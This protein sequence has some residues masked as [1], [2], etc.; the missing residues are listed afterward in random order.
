MHKTVGRLDIGYTLTQNR[1]DILHE[2][3]IASED[4]SDYHT[5]AVEHKSSTP[6]NNNLGSTSGIDRPE[7][8]PTRVSPGQANVP[9]PDSI[10]EL[11]DTPMQ[12]IPSCALTAGVVKKDCVDRVLCTPDRLSV[13]VEGISHT[14]SHPPPENFDQMQCTPMSSTEDKGLKLKFT[15]SKGENSQK[16]KR[17]RSAAGLDASNSLSDVSFMELLSGIEAPTPPVTRSK[18]K[19]ISKK[20]KVVDTGSK[21]VLCSECGE[22]VK[23]STKCL[24]C[25][26]CGAPACEKCMD[27]PKQVLESLQ[28]GSLDS[29][30]FTCKDCRDKVRNSGASKLVKKTIVPEGSGKNSCD[31]IFESKFDILAA[32]MGSLVTQMSTMS[33]TL[34]G[35]NKTCGDIKSELAKKADKEEVETLSK[36]VEA[37]KAKVVTLENVRRDMPVVQD[38]AL[39]DRMD[40]VK[41]SITSEYKDKFEEVVGRFDSLELKLRQEERRKSNVIV[42]GRKESDA[43]NSDQR[44]KEDV[45]FIDQL[46]G[47]ARSEYKAVIFRRA[48]YRLG[49]RA[50]GKHRNIKI[51]LGNQQQRDVFLESMKSQKVDNAV[52]FSIDRSKEERETY[53][54]L[55]A[56]RRENKQKVDANFKTR[57]NKD[58]P[59]SQ[60]FRKDPPAGGQ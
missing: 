25:S 47:H 23:D 33:H 3:F 54:K 39:A 20:S 36:E 15:F 38:G 53:K 35:I 5:R 31:N 48:N 32:Q 13:P 18:T 40:E 60:P 17:S 37:L 14:C 11:N 44:D 49:V 10:K 52:S 30:L 51:I 43:V 26:F 50:E 2:S 45:E 1:M 57:D 12:N 29:F 19:R 21:K 58:M 55:R 59:N 8:E 46:V 28:P 56:E 34:S 9:K 27:L 16:I 4:I 22:S 41:S 24:T 7:C 6:V 42:Y